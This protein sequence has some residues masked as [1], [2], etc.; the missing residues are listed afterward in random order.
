MEYITRY[1]SPERVA[2]LIQD[3]AD[4]G[5]WEVVAV[6][7]DEIRPEVAGWLDRAA[8]VLDCRFNVTN[9]GV[10]FRRPTKETA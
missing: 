6:F 8:T 5:G 7:P 10:V 4:G 3:Y 1:T 2:E 9:V